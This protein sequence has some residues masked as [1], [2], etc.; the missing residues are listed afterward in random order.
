MD[1]RLGELPHQFKYQINDYLI[2]TLCTVI[3]LIWEI[4]EE[5]FKAVHESIDIATLQFVNELT[6]IKTTLL[7]RNRCIKWYQKIE[8]TIANFIVRKT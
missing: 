1:L 3:Q 2:V 7:I 6:N 8:K 5:S 4:S